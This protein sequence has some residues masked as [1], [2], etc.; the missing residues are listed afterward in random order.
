MNEGWYD[1]RKSNVTAGFFEVECESAEDGKFSTGKRHMRCWFRVIGGELDGEGFEERVPEFKVLA[2]AKALGITPS[3]DCPFFATEMLGKRFSVEVEMN[4]F[5][6]L[7]TP[8]V[9]PSGIRW[10]NPP[11]GGPNSGS[12]PAAPTGDPKKTGETPF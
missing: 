6:G 3:Q 8:R 1:T 9:K 5:N 10:V 4:T 2:F 7:T 11:E 12:T